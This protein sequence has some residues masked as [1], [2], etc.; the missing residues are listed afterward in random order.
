MLVTES[1]ERN[2]KSRAQLSTTFWHCLKPERSP[3]GRSVPASRPRFPKKNKSLHKAK[4]SCTAAQAE[5]SPKG[6]N[7]TSQKAK[8]T[9]KLNSSF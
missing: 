4:H 1:P 9:F 6:R 5:W 2:Q 7:G 8:E 3:Q